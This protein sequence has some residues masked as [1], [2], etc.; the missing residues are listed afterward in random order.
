MLSWAST[1]PRQRLNKWY[2][3]GIHYKVRLALC[4]LSRQERL[5]LKY[6]SLKVS[7][8]LSI[9]CTKTSGDSLIYTG[10]SSEILELLTK[11]RGFGKEKA[12]GFVSLYTWAFIFMNATAPTINW[13]IMEWV[14]RTILRGI[15]AENTTN[16]LLWWIAQE[17][18][19][20]IW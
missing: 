18:K 1:K 15:I 11:H 7:W 19:Q 20:L 3:C 16:C 5:T 13:E 6:G 12:A 9:H 2:S 10:M 4:H 17:N 8:S 14:P